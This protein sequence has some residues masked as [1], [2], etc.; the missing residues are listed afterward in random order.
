MGAQSE[1]SHDLGCVFEDENK[2]R[3]CFIRLRELRERLC[4]EE[5]HGLSWEML[6][7]GMSVEFECAIEEGATAVRDNHAFFGPCSQSDVYCWNCKYHP[8]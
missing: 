4:Q 8:I 5:S 2:D 3:S 7:M 6:F 1:W